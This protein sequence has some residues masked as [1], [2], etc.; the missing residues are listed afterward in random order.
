MCWQLKSKIFIL[1]NSH[2]ARTRIVVLFSCKET[3]SAKSIYMGIYGKEL[4]SSFLL[5]AVK[6]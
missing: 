4:F 2:H 1:Q 3:L 6:E 5:N